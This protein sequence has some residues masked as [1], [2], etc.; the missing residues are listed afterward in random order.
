MKTLALALAAGLM[1]APAFGQ[2]VNGEYRPFY[3]SAVA[4]QQN[5]T[6]F[7]DSN[8][9][10]L[11]FANGSE[12][13]AAYYANDGTNMRLLLTG[14]LESN[15]NKLELFFDTGAAGG[16]S[17]VNG[18]GVGAMNNLNGFT[19]DTGFRANFWLSVTGGDIGGGVY[20]MFVDGAA[21]GGSGAT[22]GYMGFNDGQNGGV[23]NQEP[24][25][26]N[27]FLNALIAINNS[28]SSGVGPAGNVGSPLLAQ[29]GIEIV[30]PWAS[31][32]VAPGSEMRVMAF[33]NGGSHDYASN[34]FLGALPA[35]T[36]NLG[37]DGNGGF[38]GSVGQLNMNNFAGN[39]FF[40]IPTPGAAALLGL[41]G[42]A[43]FRRRRA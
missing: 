8:I 1:A 24:G 6:G 19:F 31:L 35:N 28:N 43:A 3:G 34:Q 36:G 13:N 21:L 17:S 30:I 7:G 33:I 12:L 22:G 5:G 41:G 23:L 39:Q 2:A 15:F 32:G 42:L 29:T 27:N 37:G 9:S 25:N 20:R 14:N 38:N 40:V 11:Q 4:V 26:S 18:T 16:Q 10:D